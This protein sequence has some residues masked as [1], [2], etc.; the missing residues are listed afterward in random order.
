MR[1]LVLSQR[2]YMNKDFIHDRYGRFREL[3][4]ALASAGHDVEGICFIYR[5][6]NEGNTNK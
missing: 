1:I 3:P 2:Q 5:P 4:L 6:R